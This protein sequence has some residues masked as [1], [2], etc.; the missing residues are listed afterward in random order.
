MPPGVKTWE[1]LLVSIQRTLQF[2]QYL[3]AEAYSCIESMTGSRYIRKPQFVAVTIL[4][5]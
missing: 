3:P 4:S 1:A 2:H 5:H